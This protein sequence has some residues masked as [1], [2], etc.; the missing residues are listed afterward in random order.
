MLSQHS[1]AAAVPSPIRSRSK[2]TLHQLRGVT[3]AMASAFA[4][5]SPIFRPVD[6]AEVPALLA[7]EQASYPEDEAASLES[8]TLRANDAAECF[9]VM[10]KA[11]TPDAPV[12]F[13]CGTRTKQD[14]LTH[15]S[16]STHDADGAI[17]CIHSVVVEET[18][19][20][21][22]LGAAMLRAYVRFIDA[23]KEQSG[24]KEMRL[25][26][27]EHLIKFYEGGGFELIGKSDVVHGKDTWFEMRLNLLSQQD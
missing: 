21:N 13:V 5:S 16:M 15:D 26:C 27:K 23:Q 19:R 18:Q 11:E 20:K 8:L 1:W 4:P 25:L 12:G 17:L 14:S 3:T 7:I 6:P 9:L 10:T 2:R 24:V 22:G